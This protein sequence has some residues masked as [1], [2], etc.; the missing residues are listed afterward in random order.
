[1]A[2]EQLEQRRLRVQR[3]IRPV[4]AFI[5]TEVA[6]GIVLLAGAVL[7][8]VWAN[9]PW[10]QS[11]RELIGTVLSVDLG[12]WSRSMDLKHW[13]NDGA[14]TLFFFLVGLEI[15]RE[16]A[17]GELA[18]VRRAIVPIAGAI[19]GMVAPALIFVA[20]VDDPDLRQGWGVAI[21]TDIAFALGI[22]ALLGNRIRPGL[23]IFLLGL[24]IVDDILAILVI[25]V[26]YTETLALAPLGLALAMLGVAYVL[27]R[28]GIWHLAPYVALG[29]VGWVALLESGVHPTIGG[30][31]FGALT[32]TRAWYHWDGFVDAAERL[33]DHVRAAPRSADHVSLH[34]R[35][36]HTLLQMQSV[37]SSTL[38]PLDRLEHALLPV[39]SF[40]I[41]PVFAFANA[42]VS[43]GGGTLGEAVTT[44]VM[45]GVLLGLTLGKPIGILAAVWLTVRAGASLPSGSGWRALLGASMLAG[46]GFTVSLFIAELAFGGTE[47]LTAAKLGILGA[48]LAAGGA[49]YVFLRVS[50]RPTPAAL[51]MDEEASAVAG[52]G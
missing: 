12:V 17:I 40:G 52:S 3:F 30:V 24:A 48:S 49:G 15:K 47:R 32:P 33:L 18:T 46:I 38:S 41:V 6:G 42:G 44:S 51:E 16:L 25:A 50:Q 37:A 19:G 22:L 9:S 5:E 34:E 21:A 23:K 7:A 29:F 45:W 13:I 26:F 10:S 39:V 4:Q 43:L 8:L 27:Q 35:E 11:Y 28:V 31:A 2:R 14:M 36:M 1:M 20:I